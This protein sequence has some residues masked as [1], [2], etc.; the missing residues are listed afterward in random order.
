V[1]QGVVADADEP[2][3]V[4]E[5]DVVPVDGRV[6]AGGGVIDD[7]AVTGTSG[8][9]PVGVGDAVPAGAVVLGGRL[10]ILAERSPVATRLA[11]VCRMLEE[12]TT[13]SPGRMAPTRHGE[14]F[15][16]KFAVPTLA[17]AGL[18]LLAGDVTTAV[19]VMRP[20]YANAE[21]I[22]VSFEDLDAVARGLVEGCVVRSPRGLD[23][24][25]SVDT[26]LIL[27]HPRLRRCGLRVSRVVCGPPEP[28]CEIEPPELTGK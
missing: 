24:L 2:R 7:R 11:I 15:G 18:G 13:W 6:V 21:A 9:R 8:A 19:A 17:T 26:L 27:D 23:A 14:A 10:T 1:V 12:A 3:A 4:D 22:S 25:A 28:D 16:E 20:D 5:G